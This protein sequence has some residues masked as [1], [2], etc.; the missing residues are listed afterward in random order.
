MDLWDRR[1]RMLG[2]H[3]ETSLLRTDRAVTTWKSD[4]DSLQYD[5][6]RISWC[7]CELGTPAGKGGA[8][9]RRGR[10]HRRQGTISR[11]SMRFD[12]R[13]YGCRRVQ[14]LVPLHS[15]TTKSD[16][17]RHEMKRL[18]APQ[19]DQHLK[20]GDPRGVGKWTETKRDSPSTVRANG[21][22]EPNAEPS[23]PA[24]EGMWRVTAVAL[25]GGA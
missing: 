14:L 9:L 17:G 6:R 19:I 10:P 16:L 18:N 25:H 8:L 24:G 3:P 2:P 1:T 13:V 12:V 4:W 20:S 21:E 23:T 7:N 15:A 5:Q 22:Y 11:C